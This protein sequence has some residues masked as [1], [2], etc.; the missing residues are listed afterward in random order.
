M[1]HVIL[2]RTQCIA[3]VLNNLSVPVPGPLLPWEDAQLI[4]SIT[5]ALQTAM[6][7]IPVAN[8]PLPIASSSQH[9]HLKNYKFKDTIVLN[10]IL[11]PDTSEDLRGKRCCNLKAT[12][13]IPKDSAKRCR[14][15]AGNLSLV[16]IRQLK[17]ARSEC[18][19]VLCW[20]QGVVIHVVLNTDV[21]L[22]VIDQYLHVHTISKRTIDCLSCVLYNSQ[23]TEGGVDGAVM[24]NFL[25]KKN[26]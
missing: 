22:H 5:A 21:L 18:M 2:P 14:K 8:N 9:C 26:H 13:T 17:L 11:A 23:V 19:S 25:L 15:C 10:N 12:M 1:A 16:P 6:A 24:R 20:H 7:S 3:L 4:T